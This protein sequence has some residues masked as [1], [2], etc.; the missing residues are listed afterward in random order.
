[1]WRIFRIITS[2]FLT[3][4]MRFSGPYYLSTNC[5]QRSRTYFFFNYLKEHVPVRYNLDKGLKSGDKFFF[6]PLNCLYFILEK[7]RRETSHESLSFCPQLS[8]SSDGRPN[9]CSGCCRVCPRTS[10]DLHPA[11]LC[12]T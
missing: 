2:L 6:W 3:L 11:V 9:R 10:G 8:E 1:M 7:I 12:A 4:A 5:K